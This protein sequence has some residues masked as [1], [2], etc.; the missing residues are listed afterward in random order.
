MSDLPN[1]YAVLGLSR[2]CTLNEIRDA[3]RLL[4]KLHH[5]DRNGGS[6]ESVTRTQ[7]L[8]AAYETLADPDRRREYDAELTAI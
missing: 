7:E 3:Y 2:R 1:H 6:A 4:A 8:N 5:P